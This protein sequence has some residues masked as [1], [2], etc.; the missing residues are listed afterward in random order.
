MIVLQTKRIMIQNRGEIYDLQCR[1]AL[2]EHV[3]LVGIE[4]CEAKVSRVCVCIEK[5]K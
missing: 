3:S 1:K 5:R 2:L 4:I